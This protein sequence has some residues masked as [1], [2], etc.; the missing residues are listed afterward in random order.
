MWNVLQLLAFYS[1]Q[2]V[3]RQSFDAHDCQKQALAAIGNGL[4]IRNK[5]TLVGYGSAVFPGFGAP[6]KLIRRS[7]RQQKK[8]SGGFVLVPEFR[9]AKPCISSLLSVEDSRVFLWQTL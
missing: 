6:T 5:A 2:N 9:S 3:V 4:G 1:K 8:A 7:L